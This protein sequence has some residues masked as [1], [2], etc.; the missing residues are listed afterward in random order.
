MFTD[1]SLLSSLCI[2]S[3]TIFLFSLHFFFL[4]L[5]IF[6][7]FLFF[8]SL[9]FILF[10]SSSHSLFSENVHFCLLSEISFLE[11]YFLPSLNSVSIHPFLI[12]LQ[13]DFFS[14]FLFLSF[15]SP[16]FQ[17][18][19]ED[20][21]NNNNNSKKN[22]EEG[23]RNHMERKFSFPSFFS[24][25]FSFFSF[26]FLFRFLSSITLS[27]LLFFVSLLPCQRS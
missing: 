16:F 8:L 12:E 11:F 6:S 7:I 22:A 21:D 27:C 17:L 9:F 23:R 10:L 26:F 14:L 18:T 1:N 5:C 20:E 2:F 13:L 19:R 3:F 4:S 25:F 24:F 15:Y